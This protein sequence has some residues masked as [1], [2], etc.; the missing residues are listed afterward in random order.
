MTTYEIIAVIIAFLGII[1]GI[2]K[3]WSK[4]QTDI[5]MINVEIENIKKDNARKD[6]DF[7]DFKTESEKKAEQM[8]LD[9]REDFQRV[10]TRLDFIADKL[11]E[12]RK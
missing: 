1:V 6:K 11:G 8:R 5:A 4:T 12:L 2:F 9:N 3:V 7:S 10:F